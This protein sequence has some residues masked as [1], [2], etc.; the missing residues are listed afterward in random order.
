MPER[1]QGSP[2]KHSKSTAMILI[3]PYDNL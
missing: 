2:E 3:H 1:I